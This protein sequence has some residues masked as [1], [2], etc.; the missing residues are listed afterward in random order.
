[1]STKYQNQGEEAIN[2]MRVKS[3]E[4]RIKN[5]ELRI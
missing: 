2:K 3:E 1:V 4:F 5:Y